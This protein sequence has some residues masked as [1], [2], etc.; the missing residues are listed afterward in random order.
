MSL[1]GGFCIP[2]LDK[3]EPL[4]RQLRKDT[5]SKPF[6]HSYLTL[7]HIFICGKVARLQPFFVFPV[8]EGFA[9]AFSLSEICK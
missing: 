4:E 6:A 3:I 8:T 5:D 1:S 7:K 2:A 9:S